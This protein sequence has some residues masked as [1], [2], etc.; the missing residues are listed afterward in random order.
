GADQ[1]LA[2]RYG[3]AAARNGE[4]F[5]ELGVVVKQDA[6]WGDPRGNPRDPQAGNAPGGQIDVRVSAGTQPINSPGT[7]C[8][9]PVAGAS[10]AAPTGFGTALPQA[11]DLGGAPAVP[12]VIQGS[13]GADV[14]YTVSDG[15]RTSV[16]STTIGANGMTGVLLD[17]TGFNDGVITVNATQMS[18]GVAKSL[19]SG[20]TG[21]SSIVPGAPV[22]SLAQYISPTNMAAYAIRI[23][24]APGTFAIFGIADER[25]LQNADSDIIPTSGVLDE[26]LDASWSLDGPIAVISALYNGNGTSAATVVGVTK[27]TVAPAV[28]VTAPRYVNFWNITSYQPLLTT[29]PGATATYVISDG[30]HSQSGSK[31]MNSSGFWNLPIN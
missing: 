26:T 4:P 11:V 22:L 28:A 29:E 13:A 5:G 2:A 17:L 10:I 30:V 27:D 8:D 3:S 19:G 16:G 6:A 1:T 20:R 21:K 24:G 18:G 7:C 14:T 25:G 15:V 31:P 9:P 12:Y 23:T